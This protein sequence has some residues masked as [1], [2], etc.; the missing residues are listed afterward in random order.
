MAHNAA[1]LIV[2]IYEVFD[3]RYEWYMRPAGK[4]GQK[5]DVSVYTYTRTMAVQCDHALVLQ[6]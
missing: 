4:R 3:L 1:L 5:Q 6:M 2:A